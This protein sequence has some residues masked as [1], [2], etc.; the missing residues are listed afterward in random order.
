MAAQRRRIPLSLRFFLAIVALVGIGGA[1]WIWFRAQRQ[2]EA[3]NGVERMVTLEGT[4]AVTGLPPHRGLIV[5]LC[6]F[7]VSAADARDP[8]DGDPPVEAATDVH[9]V[10]NQV[11]LNTELSQSSYDLPFEL[12]RPKGFYYLQ[13]RCILFRTKEDKVFAQAEQF[14]FSRRPLSLTDEAPGHLT[15]PV[16]WPQIPLEELGTYEIVEPQ[17]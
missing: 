6:F 8:F 5:S 1:T 3:V 10:A 14:Y 11:D 15:L 7:P 16:Q 13:V 9:E 2:R 17:K 4:I 12:E